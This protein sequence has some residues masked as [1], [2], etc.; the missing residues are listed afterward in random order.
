MIKILSSKRQLKLINKNEIK[1]K[2]V[3]I[4]ESYTDYITPSGKVY[5]DYGNNL[6]YP[7]K[8]HTNNHNKYVYVGITCKDGKNRQRRL[9]RLLAIAFIKNPKPEEYHVVGHLDNNKSNYN[10]DNLYWTDISENTQKAFDDQLAYNDKGIKDSQAQPIVAYKN[11]GTLISVYGSI[12]EA[13]RCIKGAYPKN[14]I[15]Y[16]LD[17]CTK[18]R[19]GLYFRSITKE[20]YYTFTGKKNLV[21]DINEI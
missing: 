10:L 16:S 20:Q 21:F 4:S 14:T 17:K 2:M 18:G 1:E 3:L 19:K 8:V 11:D 12:C 7:K 6:F 5:K 15:G 9:H 13:A